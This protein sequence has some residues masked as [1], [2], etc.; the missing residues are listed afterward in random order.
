MMSDA[1]ISSRARALRE[2]PESALDDAPVDPFPLNRG[3]V[4]R[5]LLH[6]TPGFSVFGLRLIPHEDPVVMREILI[7]SGVTIALTAVFLALHRTVRRRG[8]DN[9]LSTVISYGVCAV[10]T[11]S[12]FR[13]NLEFTCVV[14]AILAFGDSFAYF[15]GKLFGKRKLPWNPSKSWAGTLSFV[16]FA[17]PLAALAYWI[18]ARPVVP[19]A[20]AALCATSAAVAGAIAESLPTRL[21]DNLRIGVAAMVAVAAAHFAFAPYFPTVG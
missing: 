2:P 20:L 16:L 9:F 6:M 7:I 3:E 17:A 4:I 15:G 12:L 18:E 21:T 8:E 14:V 5:K 13:E 10:A 1:S 19:F 11:L